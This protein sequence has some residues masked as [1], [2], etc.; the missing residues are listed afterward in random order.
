MKIKN[1]VLYDN[2]DYAPEFLVVLE[3]EVEKDKIQQIVND[4]KTKLEGEWTY[5]DILLALNDLKVDFEVYDIQQG[6][7]IYM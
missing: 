1:F 6:N 7:Y 4:V 5:E 2:Y 3:K